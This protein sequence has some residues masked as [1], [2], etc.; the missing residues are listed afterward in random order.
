MGTAAGARGKDVDG[1]ARTVGQTQGQA[2]RKNG[3][4][5][6]QASHNHIQ[7][8]N[9]LNTGIGRYG[10]ANVASSGYFDQAAGSTSPYGAYTSTESPVITIADGDFE[11]RPVNMAINYIIKL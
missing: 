3:L 10:S 5:A 6:S 9:T 8:L 11:T 2:T 4:S 1:T 7:G